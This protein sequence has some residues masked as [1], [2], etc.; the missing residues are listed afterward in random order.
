M[1]VSTVQ[2]APNLGVASWMGSYLEKRKTTG[3]SF[4]PTATARDFSP[5]QLHQYCLRQPQPQ[6]VP[7]V[8]RMK[9]RANLH[10]DSIS[11]PVHL[12]LAFL[13]PHSESQFSPYRESPFSLFT[14][15][16]CPFLIPQVL[17]WKSPGRG[18]VADCVPI[19]GFTWE[20]DCTCLTHSL[21]YPK[22]FWSFGN[23]TQL[24]K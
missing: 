19:P 20:M 10:V 21:L 13:P 11:L 7:A 5:P 23:C 2:A 14:D 9:R 24:T 15:H 12:H 1:A 8:V 18:R 4:L 17:A 16:Q 6:V 3:T 22:V